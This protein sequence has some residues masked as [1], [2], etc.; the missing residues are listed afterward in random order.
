MKNEEIE[1]AIG[2]LLESQAKHDTQI[3]EL[4]NIIREQ[5]ASRSEL[6]QAMTQAITD[7]AEAQRRTE[8]KVERLAD[9]VDR[10]ADIVERGNARQ[11][12]TD[13]RLD[14][15]S[16]VVEKLVTRGE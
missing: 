8:T 6:N 12:E 16:E 2:F 10:L 7:L 14:R 13:A 11:N 5:S 4:H 1:R 15:L 9:K 3:A